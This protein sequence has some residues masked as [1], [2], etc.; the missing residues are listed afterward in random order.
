MAS[1][2]RTGDA[3]SMSVSVTKRID[4]M[5]AS[6]KAL[7]ASLTS[8]LRLVVCDLIKVRISR[9]GEPST[10][11]QVVGLILDLVTKARVMTEWKEKATRDFGA[12][13]PN[14]E[15]MDDKA[16]LKA[17]RMLGDQRIPL[18][19]ILSFIGQHAP[20]RGLPTAGWETQEVRSEETKGRVYRSVPRGAEAPRGSEESE[21][22]SD[23]TDENE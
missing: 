16:L 20:P 11:A 15:G 13:R 10:G 9:G 6:G 19:D 5:V 7:N 8:S 4:E 3:V 23:A 2:P 1:S 12:V 22:A 14:I 18:K 21:D 17:T